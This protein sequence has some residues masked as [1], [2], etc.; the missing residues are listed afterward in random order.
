M[1]I[2]ATAKG[3]HQME[4]TSERPHKVPAGTILDVI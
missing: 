4:K 1:T 2:T 3:I